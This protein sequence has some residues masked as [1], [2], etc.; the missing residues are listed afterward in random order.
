MIYLICLFIIFI[1]YLYI[2]ENFVTCK[3]TACKP[4]YSL[5]NNSTNNCCPTIPNV[6]S[7]T[8]TCD[9]ETCNPGYTLNNNK[10]CC[11]NIPGAI[12]YDANCK[13]T[14]CSN[15]Y[16][17]YN[18]N[19]GCTYC[20]TLVNSANN[21]CCGAQPNAW[22]YNKSNCTVK[23]CSTHLGYALQSGRCIKCP[24]GGVM[25]DGVTCCPIVEGIDPNRNTYSFGNCEV[26]GCDMN[27]YYA[28]KG[29]TCEK[30]AYGIGAQGQCCPKNDEYENSSSPN[31]HL[32]RTC[33]L[34][35]CGTKDNPGTNYHKA[36]GVCCIN[37]VS[38]AQYVS[39]NN[40]DYCDALVCKPQ[41]TM[42]NKN[43][44]I[45]DSMGRSEIIT[46]PTCQ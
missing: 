41:G 35:V 6:K 21:G 40:Y 20:S 27:N 2:D 22:E 15:N 17:Y 9:P 25:Y 36:S 5:S 33:S 26:G 10:K 46:V 16:Y 34:I 12:S 38:L 8:S 31:K 43:Y 18:N 39:K 23:T 14:S 32:D 1:L 37:S 28:P 24:S 45:Y 3:L 7:Y 11:T 19:G 44:T 13:A 29:T 4:G 42:V 30:C